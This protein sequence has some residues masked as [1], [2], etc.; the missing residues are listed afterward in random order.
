MGKLTPCAREGLG[1]K[2]SI[3]LHY[4]VTWDIWFGL[5]PQSWDMNA[6]EL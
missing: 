4:G 5:S 3:P 2:E 1:A 6:V